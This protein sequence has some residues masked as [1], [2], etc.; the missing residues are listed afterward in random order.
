[1]TRPPI[2]EKAFARADVR[3]VY[4]ITVGDTVQRVQVARLGDAECGAGLRYG[5]RVDDGPIRVVEATRPVDDVLSL[6]IEDAAWEAGLVDIDDGFDVEVLGIRH[7]VEVIDPR[8]K[9]LRMAAGAT[10]GVVKT[11]MPGR[12]VRLLVGEG[13]EVEKGAPLV[14]VEAMKMEN[15]LR[16]PREGTVRRIAVSP[17]DLVEAGTVLVELE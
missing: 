12:V 13:D 14:V 2:D 6:L 11:A 7:Q 3:G 15:E 5:V 4:E 9:A 1:M 16:A 8:R 17:G 10:G